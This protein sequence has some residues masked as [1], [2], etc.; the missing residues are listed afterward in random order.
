LK[1]TVLRKTFKDKD[2]A[3]PFVREGTIKLC[4]LMSDD[5]LGRSGRDARGRID[6]FLVSK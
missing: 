1:G 2:F 3:T 4:Q 5:W 6:I